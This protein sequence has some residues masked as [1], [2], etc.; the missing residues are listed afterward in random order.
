MIQLYYRDL[1]R[2]V[3]RLEEQYARQ[4]P[5]KVVVHF[6]DENGETWMIAGDGIDWKSCRWK[7][8][9]PDPCP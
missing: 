5:R 2:R 8:A 9:A 7:P 1:R 3:E 4:H 6:L